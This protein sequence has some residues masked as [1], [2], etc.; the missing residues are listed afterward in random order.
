MGTNDPNTCLKK[1][2]YELVDIISLLTNINAIVMENLL[3]MFTCITQTHLLHPSC[4]PTPTYMYIQ[5]IS[6]LMSQKIAHYNVVNEDQT[7]QYYMSDA[8]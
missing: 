4:F 7:K 5:V 6:L 2:C 1:Y 3:Q 8:T